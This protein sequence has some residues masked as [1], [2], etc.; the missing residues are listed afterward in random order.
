MGTLADLKRGIVQEC[1][2]GPGSY[3]LD[4][5]ALAND[6]L[7]DVPLSLVLL[8]DFTIPRGAIAHSFSRTIQATNNAVLVSG[9]LHL[10][11]IPLFKGMKVTNISFSSGGTPAAAPT[12]QKFGLYNDRMELVA[13]T[14]NDGATAWAANTIKTLALT[15]PYDVPASGVYY[16]AILVVAGTVP[17]LGSIPASGGLDNALNTNLVQDYRPSAASNSTA[18]ADLPNPAGALNVNSAAVPYCWVA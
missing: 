11:P 6:D 17:S 8:Q 15:A 4:D 13:S 18:L 12:F 10:V 3:T 1:M 14:N 5:A 9:R 2:V 16:V 7:A